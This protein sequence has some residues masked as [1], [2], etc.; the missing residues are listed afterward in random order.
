MLKPS[1]SLA[2]IAG[3]WICAVAG[4][5]PAGD[6]SSQRDLDTAIAGIQNRYAGV[7]SIRADFRQSYRGPAIDRTESGSMEMKRP[8]LMH[9]EYRVP[10]AKVFVA[11][12]RDT[13]LYTPEDR[14]VLVRRYSADDLRGTPLQIFLGRDDI[15]KSFEVAW[16]TAQQP[17]I[18]GAILL[19]LIPRGDSAEYAY[20]VIEC[21]QG[22]YDVRR[23]MIRE[24]TG[25]TS[26]FVFSNVQT[27]VKIDSRQFQFK[28]PKGV[29]VVRVD[30]K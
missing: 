27:N 2:V 23:V 7:E 19:R 22:S 5:L 8:N 17:L 1:R 20:T 24:R 14:Q 4:L 29:E 9:W 16:E 11:D 6:G 12:G 3:A 15:R 25:N 28:I 18:Q 30:E 13:Y 10:E 26:E 21:D